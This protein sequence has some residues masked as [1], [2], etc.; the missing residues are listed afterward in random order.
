VLAIKN[1]IFLQKRQSRKTPSADTSGKSQG[2]HIKEGS[3]D[4]S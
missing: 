1:G 3:P 2:G 4:A